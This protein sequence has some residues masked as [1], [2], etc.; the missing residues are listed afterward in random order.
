M[1]GTYLR[2]AFR[3]LKKQRPSAAISVAG[4]AIG[5]AFFALLVAYVRDDLTF[6]RFHAKGDQTY[7]LTVEFRDRFVGASHHFVAGMLEADYPEVAPGSS[8]RYAMHSQTVR[9]GAGLAVKDFAFAD[10]GFFGMFSFDL[11]AGDPV[12]ALAEPHGAVLTAS[13]A[14]A[15]GLPPNPLGKTLSIRVGERFEDFAVTGVIRDIP[16][17]SS[18]RFDGILPFRRVFD[19]FQ[20]DGNNNDLV[21]LPMFSVTFLDLPDPAAAAS[22][23]AKL[24]A[25]N[26][27]LYGEMW[28]RVK[29]DPPKRGFDLLRLSDYHLGEVDVFAL[30][31]RSRPAFSWTLSAIALLVLVLAC[32]NSLNLSLA[33]NS[34]RLKEAGV[35]KTI[36]ARKGQLI[37]QLLTESFVAGLASLVLGLGAAALLVPSFNGL[38]GKRLSPAGLVHPQTL[39]VM[40]A[41]ILVV[42]VFTG[43][44]PAAALSRVS[45]ADVLR[46]RLAGV[47]RSRLTL[48]L[49]VFQ[50]TASIVFL[51]GS[52]VM[53]RQLR[54]MATADL[55]YDP[56]DIL[57]VDTQV[58]QEAGS[59]DGALV[60]VFRNALRS[61]P[62][63]LAVSADSGTVGTSDHGSVTRRYDKDGVEHEVEAFLIDR[64][65][66]EVLGLPL[67]AGRGFSPER[68]ADVRDGILVNEAFVK[69][70][71]LA[72]PVGK[73]FSEFAKD[74]FPP[75][76][77]FV[78]PSGDRAHGLRDER[79][80]GHP[81]VGQHSGQDAAGRDGGRPEK[82]RGRLVRNPAGRPL[83]RQAARRR[84]GLGIPP[85]LELEPSGLVGRRLLLAHRLP[86]TV[87]VD[88]HL[89]R[90][91]DQGD[92][93]PQGDGGRDVGHLPPVLAGRPEMGVR[94]GRPVLAHRLCRGPEMAGRLR[95]QDRPRPL[96]VRRGL[97]PGLPGRGSDHEL[98]Y[99]PDG[100]GRAGPQ[101]PLRM[102]VRQSRA[103]PGPGNL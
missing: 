103:H 42:C 37:A 66:L 23:R 62:R 87:R 64:D 10:P 17:N 56:S 43:L 92:R 12:R 3:I 48:G 28:R 32:F 14:R 36:G 90:P 71:G 30:A 61:D 88:G 94:G 2:T 93:H 8:V 9:L 91:A 52:L 46:G 15:L 99:P 67:V 83:R 31:S 86:G 7:V 65:F 59:D 82:A 13:T 27:R 75:E 19:A 89:R 95:L 53:A 60:A 51:V 20:V 45:A 49:I 72:D 35:R 33:R 26:D 97:L 18:L 69:D 11:V 98:A 4:L 50:F 57:I 1:L 55:G 54:F 100:P 63:V 5:L 34:A 25:L 85:R 21:T 24:P 68:A 73:R 38:T 29:M 22:L 102:T 70:F 96:D 6:D 81:A 41:S 77:T 80:A 39:L 84:P 79:N 76:Y 40:A 44:I 58:P 78:P 101:P 16:G 47:K 74:K